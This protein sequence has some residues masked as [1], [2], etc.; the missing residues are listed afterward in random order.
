[1]YE[2]RSQIENAH[3][4]SQEDWEQARLIGYIQ[5]QSHTSKK[6]KLTDIIKFPWEGEGG[7]K[8]KA[9]PEI[10]SDAD[11]NRLKGKAQWMID[12]GMI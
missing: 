7:K 10:M 4:K 2:V 5:A 1:M 8:A 6:L 12:N 3:Y 11:L 9:Q